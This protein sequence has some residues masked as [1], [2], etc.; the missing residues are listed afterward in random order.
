MLTFFLSIMATSPQG[1]PRPPAEP[2]ID[3]GKLLA[4]MTVEEKVGQLFVVDGRATTPPEGSADFE[5]LERQVTERHVGGVIW[6]RSKVRETAVW[7]ARLQARARVPLLVAADLEAGM[8]MRFEETPWA[9]WAMAVAA[10]G[11][12]ALAEALGYQTSVEA[13]A[14]GVNQI[15]APVADVNIDPDNPVI[16]TR[17]FGEDPQ[18]VAA[19]VAAFCRGCER[20]RVLATVKHFPG[21][22]DTATDSHRSLPVVAANRARLDAVELVPFRRAFAVG[23]RAVMVG[24]VAAP[25]LDPTPAPLRQGLTEKVYGG[26]GERTEGGTLPATVS[27]AIVT[28]LLRKELGFDGLVVTDAMDMG[29]L[30]D[31]FDPA[32]GAVRA[33]EAGCDQ[34][35]KSGE[36]ERAIDAV[37]AAVKS[38]RISG[39][40]LDA[41][42]RRILKEKARLHP[43]GVPVDPAPTA[44]GVK[45]VGTPETAALLDAIARR[46]ITLVR[47]GGDLPLDR[48]QRLALVVVCDDRTREPARELTEEIAT[49]QGDRV[50]I[51]RLGPDAAAGEGVL[52]ACHR[53]DK[54]VLALVVRARTGAGAI[55]VP[56]GARALVERLTNAKKPVIGVSLGSPYLV[57]DV[58]GLTTYVVAYGDAECS[59]RAAARALYGEAQITGRL[60][61]SIPGV[62]R[63]GAGIVKEKKP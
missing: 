17:S 54:V 59:Q 31:H 7:T 32:E 11:D 47:D 2:G 34:I 19:L 30:S 3:V 23:C 53:A 37:A 18:S 42:V 56:A 8:G 21:H 44:A 29:G 43:L 12:P 20:G 25:A 4:S 45:G 5:R 57:R 58:P 39:E 6:F 51:H 49:R 48:V 22:G 10:T 52:E 24:H 35:L 9:P 50:R 1:G 14:L 15:Y 40:R 26:E 33:I 61:V 36:P 27:T 60:P 28:G 63:R 13:R 46:S 55:A 16:N 62:A 41:S 38:R